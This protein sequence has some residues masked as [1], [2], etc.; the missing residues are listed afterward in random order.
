MNELVAGVV[1]C[2]VVWVVQVHRAY[3][4]G[5][6]CLFPLLRNLLRATGS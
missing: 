5:G 3:L 1:W 2:G 4:L 6:N